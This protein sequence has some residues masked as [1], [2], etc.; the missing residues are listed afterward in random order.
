MPPSSSWPRRRLLLGSGGF[1]DDSKVQFLIT[2]MREH[3]GELDE[4]LFI[5]YAL[6]DYDAYVE[7]FKKNVGM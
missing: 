1:R 4:L 2:A 3:F 7:M 6:K 5:P